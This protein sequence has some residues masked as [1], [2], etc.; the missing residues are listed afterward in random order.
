MIKP[1]GVY[2]LKKQAAKRQQVKDRL[3]IVA[4]VVVFYLLIFSS[5][6]MPIM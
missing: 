5:G 1:L 4:A 3:T 6:L 2:R